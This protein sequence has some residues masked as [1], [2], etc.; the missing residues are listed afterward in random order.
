MRHFIQMT[1][2]THLNILGDIFALRVGEDVCM[3]SIG[4]A[5]LYD[6]SGLIF[7]ATAFYYWRRRRKSQY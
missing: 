4:D 2:K 3:Y 7:P 5:M 6:G 1:D